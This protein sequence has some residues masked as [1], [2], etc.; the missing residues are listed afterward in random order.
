MFPGVQHVLMHFASMRVLTAI[1]APS[2]AKVCVAG[3]M[4]APSMCEATSVR[5]RQAMPR[6]AAPGRSVTN[7]VEVLD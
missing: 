6:F 1:V 5:V 4:I 7:D 3:S 2:G